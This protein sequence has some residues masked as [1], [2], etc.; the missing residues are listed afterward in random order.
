[1]RRSPRVKR[2]SSATACD[3]TARLLNKKR[4]SRRRVAKSRIGREAFTKLSGK[5]RLTLVGI[6]LREN[7]R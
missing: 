4:G 1:V 6:A 5:R 7:D 3:M 2:N